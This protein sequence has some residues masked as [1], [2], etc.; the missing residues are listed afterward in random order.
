MKITVVIL[1]G[2]SC[3]GKTSIAKEICKQ[4]TAN[5]VHLQID[6]T[7]K[8]LFTILDSILTPRTISRKVCDEILLKTADT[9]IN[10]SHNVVID[11]TFNAEDGGI[12]I[13]NSYINH[14][15]G[16]NVVFIGIDCNLEERLQRFQTYNNNPARNEEEIRRQ[17]NVFSQCA[18]LYDIFFDTSHA[19]AENIAKDILQYITQKFEDFFTTNK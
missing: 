3:A 14:F 12:S 5:F 10:N 18:N 19:S 2:P 4:S 15:N 6:E 7:K 1:N 17:T 9:I 16:K 8:Y 11:T 13:A